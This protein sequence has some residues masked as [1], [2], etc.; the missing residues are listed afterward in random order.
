MKIV[1][2]SDPAA[3]P[4]APDLIARIVPAGIGVAEA[5]VGDHAA[6]L[7]P[8]EAAHIARA[9]EKRRNEFSTGRMLARR[10]LRGVDG[11]QVAIPSGEHMAPIWPQGFIGSITHTSLRAAAAVG[12]AVDFQGIGIDL[13]IISR[14][15]L[16]FSPKVATEPESELVRASAEPALHLALLYSAKESWFKCQYPLTGAYLGFQD[17]AI[18]FD[19]SKQE[20]EVRSTRG[21]NRLNLE[22]RAKGRF[23]FDDHNVATVATLVL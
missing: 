16:S 9:V 3:A 10:A 2:V 20:F 11:P 14:V 19:W 23:T 1:T 8:E 7:Y 12:R 17:A 15:S 6:D 18:L 4:I 13:E 5:T 22:Q 21:A